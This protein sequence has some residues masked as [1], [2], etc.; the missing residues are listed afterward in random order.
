MSDNPKQLLVPELK[1]AHHTERQTLYAV[2]YHD[3]FD[4]KV[5]QNY[6]ASLFMDFPMLIISLTHG[7][8]FQKEAHYYP[9]N[10]YLIEV[11]DVTTTIR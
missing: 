4:K 10:N 6:Y 2:E 11:S 8:V 3:I 9:S 5:E 1:V 7:F